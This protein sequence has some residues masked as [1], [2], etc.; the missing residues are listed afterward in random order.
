M[1]LKKALQCLTFQILGYK[2]MQPHL[3]GFGEHC[4]TLLIGFFSE[5]HS[6]L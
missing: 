3:A 6:W 1:A 5:P 2:L 4:V